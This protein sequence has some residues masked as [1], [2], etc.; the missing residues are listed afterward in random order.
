MLRRVVVGALCLAAA[1]PGC[2]AFS[3]SLPATATTLGAARSISYT[4]SGRVSLAARQ[5]SVA[6]AAPSFRRAGVT[7]TSMGVLDGISA[8]DIDGKN[9]DLGATYGD[10]PAVLVVNLASA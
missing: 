2:S 8:S 7:A 1:A 9:V 10:V 6:F 4:A 3:G 5:G